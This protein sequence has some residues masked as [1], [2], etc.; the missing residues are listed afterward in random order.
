MAKD[1]EDKLTEM[2]GIRVSKPELERLDALATRM[3]IVTRHA[4]ARAALALG[5]D[6]IEKDPTVLLGGPTPKK[7]RR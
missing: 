4:L 6:A 3:P 1:T 5:L 2:L 7:A